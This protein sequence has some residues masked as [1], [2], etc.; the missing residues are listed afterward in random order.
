MTHEGFV[1]ESCNMDADLID[2]QYRG[3]VLGEYN[4]GG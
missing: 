1:A 4:Q 2:L 3:K